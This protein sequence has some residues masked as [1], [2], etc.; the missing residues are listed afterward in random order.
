MRPRVTRR[1]M[2]Y[3]KKHFGFDPDQRRKE[4]MELLVG[5]I[6]KRRGYKEVAEK[7][8]DIRPLTPEEILEHAD[9]V[10]EDMK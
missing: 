9:N 6:S 3:A 1:E 10:L 5:P 2:E 8:L 4:T 7:V